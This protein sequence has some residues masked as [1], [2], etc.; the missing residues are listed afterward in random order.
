[1]VELEYTKFKPDTDANDGFHMM[2]CT[3]P[4]E[5]PL[6]QLTIGVISIDQSGQVFAESTLWDHGLKKSPPGMTIACMTPKGREEF[7]LHGPNTFVLENHSKG[8]EHVVYTNDPVKLAKAREHEHAY[9]QRFFDA[10]RKWLETPEGL[11]E[12]Q[13][14]WKKHPSGRV[15]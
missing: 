13:A 12:A 10:H 15:Y 11:A 6:E 1:M 4:E 5:E 3:F 2:V 8:S 14:Y 9:A 7:F